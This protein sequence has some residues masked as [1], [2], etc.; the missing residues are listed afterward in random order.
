M[1]ATPLTDQQLAAS[2][3]EIL[4]ALSIAGA[5]CGE[6]GFEPG[7]IGCSDCVRV[8][9]VYT[10]AVL[11]VVQP[12]LDRLAAELRRVNAD[13]SELVDQ[14]SSANEAEDAA[15]AELGRVRAELATLDDLR[16]RALDKNERLRAELGA[17]RDQLWNLLAAAEGVHTVLHDLIVAEANP[18]ARARSAWTALDTALIAAR[19]DA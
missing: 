4:A 3:K 17:A 18:G 2:R 7:E 6:C 19:P 12:E 9:E 15:E 14:L 11:A 5:F 13:R 8:R 16:L 10:D 1:T